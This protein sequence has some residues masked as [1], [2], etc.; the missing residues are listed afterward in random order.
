M[1]G[2]TSRNL[3]VSVIALIPKMIEADVIEDFRPISLIGSIYKVLAKVLIG[4]IQKVLPNII[5]H[6]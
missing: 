2:E 6:L 5:S 1:L 3:G 4:R